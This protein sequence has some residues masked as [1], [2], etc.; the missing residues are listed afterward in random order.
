[1]LKTV[2][3]RDG[4]TWTV[5]SSISWTKPALADQF[6]HDMAAGYVGGIAM[7]VVVVALTLFLVFWTPVGVERPAWFLQLVL[8]VLLVM[9]VLW[10]VQRPWVV[11]AQTD[12]PAG[13][14]GEHWEGV[15]RGMVTAR[16]ET[17][18]VV[19]DLQ[20]RG[21]PDNGVGPLTRLTADPLREP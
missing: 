7:M 13:T 14:E 11:T 18:R 6:E 21:V 20:M 9:P 17:H 15:V 12:E 8:L 4:R 1:M 3:S 5:R 19:D 16:E 10:A 2:R